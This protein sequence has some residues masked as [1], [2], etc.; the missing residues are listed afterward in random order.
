VL[1]GAEGRYGIVRNGFAQDFTARCFSFSDL[2]A[3]PGKIFN[4]D[5]GGKKH[6]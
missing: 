5:R 1:V 6:D 2:A 4:A 3:D